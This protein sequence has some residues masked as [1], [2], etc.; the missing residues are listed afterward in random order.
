MG[1]HSDIIPVPAAE[2]FKMIFVLLAHSPINL[3]CY[4]AGGEEKRSP[5]SRHLFF[6]VNSHIYS[7]WA[8]LKTMLDGKLHKITVN[9][10]SGLKNSRWVGNCSSFLY[11]IVNRAASESKCRQAHKAATESSLQIWRFKCLSCCWMLQ[12]ITVCRTLE[13][14]NFV[15]SQQAHPAVTLVVH[16]ENG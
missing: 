4:Y 8:G 3:H 13:H 2:E 12:H 11:S 16:L 7:E 5:G 10:K 14:R 1:A 6:K 9:M 15:Y